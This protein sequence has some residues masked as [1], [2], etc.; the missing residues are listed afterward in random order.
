MKVRPFSLSR[1]VKESRGGG[2]KVH[3]FLK[4][5]APLCS[6]GERASAINRVGYITGGIR[7]DLAAIACRTKSVVSRLA[8]LCVMKLWGFFFSSRIYF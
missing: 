5:L 8:V 4:Y 1:G 7:E 2:E 6:A 3:P